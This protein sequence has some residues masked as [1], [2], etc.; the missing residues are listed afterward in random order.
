MK[1]G[2]E[3]ADQPSDAHLFEPSSSNDDSTLSPSNGSHGAFLRA[4]S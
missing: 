1:N 2:S 3:H 4:A